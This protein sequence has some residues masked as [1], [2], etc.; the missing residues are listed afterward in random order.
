LRDNDP[1][2]LHSKIEESMQELEP[3][4]E[5]DLA[6]DHGDGA[7]AD[8]GSVVARDVDVARSNVDAR[9]LIERERQMRTELEK[10]RAELVA[11]DAEL[12]QARAQLA[13]LEGVPPQ[14]D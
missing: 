13:R 5:E 8:D 12:Q 10:A 6:T 1:D 7:D 2:F 9:D 4:P 14:R 11:K 3:E